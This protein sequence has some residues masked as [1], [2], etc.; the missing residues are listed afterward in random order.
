MRR[1]LPSFAFATLAV[2]ATWP[3]AVAPVANVPGAER[4]D[5]WDSLWSLWFF[6]ERVA[7][8]VAPTRVD[9]LLNHPVGGTLWV[10]DP[11][12]AVLATPLVWTIG[13]AA[14]WTWLV[15]AH[16]TFAGLAAYELGR[17]LGGPA[18][19]WV[20][21]VVYASAPMLMAHVHNGASE[22]VGFGWLAL[23]V[24]AQV[25]LAF[26]ERPG[27]LRIGAA[28][29]A[30]AVCAA[31]HWYA[32]VGAW[33][34]LGALVVTAPRR[35]ALVTAGLLA[36]GLVA[37]LAVGAHAAAT[38]SDNVVGIKTAREIATVRRTIGPADPL[39][40]LAPFDYRSPDF[41]ELSRYGENY[42]HS[43]YLGWIALAAA[44][45]GFARSAR[46]GDPAPRAAAV[47]LAVA[48]TAGLVL[49]CGPVLVQNGG[50]VI[51]PGRLAVP[52]P[53]LLLES[54]PGF[55]SL[56]L[57]W[58]L[59]QVGVLA[60]AVLAGLAVRGRPAAAAALCI[61]V[62]LEG[63]VVA[64]TARMPE[65]SDGRH[66]DAIAALAAEPDG[67][68]M[69]YPVSG[70]Q[71]VLYDQAAHH[72]ALTGGLNFPNNN[73]SRKVWKTMLE[74]RDAP[75]SEFLEATTAAARQQGVR[76]VIVRLDPNARPDMHDAAVRALK[77][78]TE[79]IAAGPNVRVYR[80]W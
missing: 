59:G 18:T 46:S 21:G 74:H 12:N 47:A 10:A 66:E 38:A 40:Y 8:G 63:R 36:L 34:V 75:P 60:I 41:R 52:M 45:A 54:V 48:G 26:H 4:T 71:S 58:R 79:P 7:N 50:P 20:A 17:R 77:H 35:L 64:P 29:L 3:A 13:P 15:I 25:D 30:M 32:A 76:Y 65:T 57:T 16:L 67:A 11:V 27:P 43:P 6:A 80:L 61:G 28:A 72:K 42:I 9:G 39:A 14:A 37:P 78:A 33:L 51:L 53:Y 70:G 31:A 1:A 24:L 56:S 55:S 62:L 44:L 19:A 22:A 68:A 5:L 49:A 69:V 23:A 73:A 2:F